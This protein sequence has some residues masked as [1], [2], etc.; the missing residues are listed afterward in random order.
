MI[1]LFKIGDLVTRISHNNDVV[2]KI[3]AINNDTVYL[4]GMSVR[5]C[6]DSHISDLILVD[7]DLKDEDRDFYEKLE[8]I[9]SFERNDYFYIPGKIL[10]IDTDILLSNNPTKPYK[11]RKKAKIRN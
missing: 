6:A 5:L 9:R 2:F 1:L 10:H 7:K 8:S 3:E 11:I 4:K